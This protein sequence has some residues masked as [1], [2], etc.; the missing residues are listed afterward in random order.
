MIQAETMTGPG[1]VAEDR[2]ASDYQ[3]EGFLADPGGIDPAAASIEVALPGPDDYYVWVRTYRR[4]EDPFGA[5]LG[6]AGRTADFGATYGGQPEWIW[7]RLGPFPVESP[8]ATLSIA[9]P[10]SGPAD[11][12]IAL[13]FDAVAVTSFDSF[14]PERDDPYPVVERRTF[15]IQPPALEGAVTVDLSPGVYACTVTLRDDERMV[16]PW[17]EIGVQSAPVVFE[18]G[19]AE[20]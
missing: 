5:V 20:Q 9:R 12:F 6:F 17:G 18:V 13:F 8:T 10:Y 11:R 3:G 16:D 4:V 14:D 7:E 2:F 15:S 19:G 1:W